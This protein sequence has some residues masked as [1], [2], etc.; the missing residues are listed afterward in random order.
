MTR[1]IDAAAQFALASPAGQRLQKIMRQR[2]YRIGSWSVILL[3]GLLFLS[4]LVVPWIPDGMGLFSD[5][6]GPWYQPVTA[7]L[8]PHRAFLWISDNSLVYSLGRRRR[9]SFAHLLRRPGDL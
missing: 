8:F 5:G 7:L 3:P 4:A 6:P 2:L 9:L 1:L